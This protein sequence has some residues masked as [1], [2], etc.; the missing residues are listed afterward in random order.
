MKLEKQYNLFYFGIL[1]V[2]M[3]ACLILAAGGSLV[4]SDEAFSLGM[5]RLEYCEIWNLPSVDVHPPLYY[6]YLKTFTAIFGESVFTAK[7]ASVLPYLFILAFGGRKLRYL[8]DETT[9]ILFMVLFLCFT[10]M[11]GF[12]V[13]IRMYSL[14][15]AF[16][17]ANA[18]YAYLCLK[19]G[20]RSRNWL[21]LSLFS[22]G[23]AYTHYYALAA[24]AVTDLLLLAAICCK[25]PENIRKN[26]LSVAL[27]GILYFPWLRSFTGQ[28]SYKIQNEFWI[29]GITIRTLISYG[30]SLF[31]VSGLHFLSVPLA[32]TYLILFIQALKKKDIRLTVIC[33]LAVPLGTFLIG[34][35]LSFL[36]RPV[37]VFRYIIPAISLIP[38]CTA[39]TLRG[40]FR[41][42]DGKVLFAVVLVCGLIHYGGCVKDEYRKVEHPMDGQWVAQHEEC[43]AWL[44]LTSDTHASTVLAYY[45]REKPIYTNHPE[46]GE[47]NPFPNIHLAEMYE[48][49]DRIA[50]MLETW[51]EIP[52]EI[53][54]DYDVESR[55][56]VEDGGGRKI[57]V[58]MMKRKA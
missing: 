2:G 39:L 19:E 15:A 13:E 5:I 43:D 23:A 9:G 21:L 26:I 40:S 51:A 3:I 28:M 54:K 48:A 1:F 7:L 45:E 18:V 41:R 49:K 32:V 17:F 58:Y 42:V 6:F 27:I 38:V 44:V 20:G 34:M 30:A 50:L 35:I 14:G 8:F 33:I 46:S 24:A 25:K 36:I 53:L 56:W 57:G 4:W 52:E 37:F 10:P 22:A 55:E 29:E 11:L 31:N 47:A 16:V 12:A